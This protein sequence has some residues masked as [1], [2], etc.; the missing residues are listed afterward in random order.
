MCTS[1]KNEVVNL[2]TT[3]MYARQLHIIRYIEYTYTY[4]RMHII[5]ILIDA[6][7]FGEIIS[8]RSSFGATK[9]TDFIWSPSLLSISHFLFSLSFFFDLI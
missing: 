8:K 7:S 4:V 6:T 5:Y 1:I 9:V 2:S 3:R